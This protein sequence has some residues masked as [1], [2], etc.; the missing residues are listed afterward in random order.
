VIEQKS[1]VTTLTIFSDL[2]LDDAETAA[3]R[4]GLAPHVLVRAERSPSS[5]LS[6][7]PYSLDGVDI[8]FGQPDPASVL[9]SDTVRWVHV[10]S[11]GFARY[12]TPEFRAAAVARG[13]VL[14]NS[15]S[16]YDEPC[17]EHALAFILAQARQLPRGLRSRSRAGS[18]EWQR[19]RGDC[20]LLHDQTLVMLGYGAIAK[21]LVTLLAPFQMQVMALRRRPRGD[22]TVPVV[23]EEDLAGALAHAD[24]VVNIL[25]D[26]AASRRFVDSG[27]L[28][29]MKPGAV[30]Y[31]IG[32]G[33][34]VDQEALAQALRSGR[35]AAAWLDV[36]D[37]EPL[38]A[39]HPLLGLE[40][41]HITPHV[42]GGHQ[43]ESRSLVR[44]FLA[45]FRRFLH[46]S[47]LHDRIL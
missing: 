8:A 5:V 34:T 15:S 17:A 24:H 33:T 4:E 21:R 28:S 39:D 32:R 37:P 9:A 13:L 38:P 27:R 25:P 11:A 22:E 35:L 6:S 31:N 7:V 42:A 43:G 16:V 20:R 12:D 2:R 1:V 44:H 47:P 36:T 14:S 29:Q 45:N 41:C 10:T 46:G 3:L 26:N 30:F 40:N 23:T 19:L 18:D